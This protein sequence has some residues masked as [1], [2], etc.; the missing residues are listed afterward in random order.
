M[1]NQNFSKDNEVKKI[2]LLTHI[3]ADNLG[4]QT[5]EV[6]AKAMVEAVMDNLNIGSDKYELLSV[7][8][9]FVNG[10]YL[11][12]QSKERTKNAEQ[13]IGDAD[14][15]I[16]GGAPMFNYLYEGFSERTAKTLDIIKKYS[17]PVIFSAIGVENY[18]EKNPKCIRLK[19]ALSENDVRMITTRDNYEA[20]Q[21]F[22]KDTD[23]PIAKV[24]DSAV[25]SSAVYAQHI[26]QNKENKEK[27]KIGL[28]VIRGNAFKDN[29]IPFSQEQ[30]IEL[31][32]NLAA[33]LEK[34]G[35]DYEFITS[36]SHADEAFL[37][38]IVVEYGIDNTKCV[39]NLNVSEDFVAQ[40]ASYDGMVACRLHPS[41]IAYS[42]QVPTVALAWN[43]KVDSFYESIGYSE[44]VIHAEE[45]NHILVADKLEQA[46]AE[47]VTR[48]ENFLVSSY[49]Y[50]FNAMKEVLCP[51]TPV[52]AFSY[53]ELIMHLP[54]YQGSELES[55]LNWK[56]ARLYRTFNQNLTTSKKWA[57]TIQQDKKN[58]DALL[59]KYNA[60]EQKY[61]STYSKM[62]KI[63]E[64]MS[65]ESFLS[66][67]MEQ[68]FPIFY[69]I[70]KA[71]RSLTDNVAAT[72]REDMGQIIVHARSIE[73]VPKVSSIQNNGTAKFHEN[74][75]KIDGFQ[76]NGWRVRVG[77][78]DRRYLLLENDTFI[79]RDEYKSNI[80]GSYKVY[81][82][83]EIIPILPLSNICNCVFEGDWEKNK[84]KDL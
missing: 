38:R 40:I 54:V 5:I 4:D 10:R 60:L 22:V 15:I 14:V 68:K 19:K 12:M 83:G 50:L 2:L 31:W 11:S 18:E 23:I 62:I 47:G 32:L 45:I 81:K 66:E 69:N 7:D 44:R 34:R 17:K 27:K 76:F 43:N 13:L 56:F 73:L 51:E 72:Y 57:E 28:F 29:K 80:H 16:F 42:L 30:A 64:E 20:L 55:K 77:I 63:A 24:S 59:Q 46:I 75:F 39:T 65:I 52:K 8:A 61:I 1:D 74:V 58:Y 82:P 33:E 70:G 36:G 35:Y 26:V 78:G 49:G 48:E 71:A 67:K 41:I 21:G 37:E 53:K 9:S 3:T 25:L 79:A 84:E 6:C